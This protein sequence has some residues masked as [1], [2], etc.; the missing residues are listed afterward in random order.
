MQAQLRARETA[1]PHTISVPATAG[2]KKCCSDQDHCVQQ[3]E[4]YSH[5]RPKAETTPSDWTGAVLACQGVSPQYSCSC[6]HTLP[7]TKRARVLVKHLYHRM[8]V[9]ARDFQA[10]MSH[11]VALRTMLAVHRIMTK[12][13]VTSQQMRLQKD[14]LTAAVL[15]QPQHG[16]A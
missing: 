16:Q 13:Q 14:M 4:G 10:M 5:C 7:S 9:Q 2:V 3:N 12:H 1:H 11:L 8:G 15:K 6:D